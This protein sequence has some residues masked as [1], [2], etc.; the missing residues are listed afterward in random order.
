MADPVRLVL[1]DEQ[2]LADVD[3]G[4]LGADVVYID[5]ALGENEVRARRA[6]LVGGL[7]EV[8]RATHVP[9]RDSGRR[10]HRRRVELG[11]AGGNAC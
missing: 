1:V 11:H 3:D 5:P 4:V 7:P 10:Q 6:L 2:D 8:S 9:H